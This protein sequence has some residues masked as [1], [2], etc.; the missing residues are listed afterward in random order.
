M[1]VECQSVG[2]SAIPHQLKTHTVDERP[3]LVRAGRVQGEGLLK[4]G[5]VRVDDFD[6]WI[7]KKKRDKHHRG[8]TGIVGAGE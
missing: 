4:R 3:L 2:D 7:F 8:P 5:V 6:G 1:I